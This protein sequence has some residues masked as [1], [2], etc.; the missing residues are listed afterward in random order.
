[1]A[2]RCPSL[3]SSSNEETEA[4]RGHMVV[5]QDWPWMPPPPSLIR[6]Q[7]ALLSQ[8]GSLDH[9]GHLPLLPDPWLHLQASQQFLNQIP[10]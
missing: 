3:S 5:R 6:A 8:K 10:L 2:L 7:G 4:Q 9:S 1:M